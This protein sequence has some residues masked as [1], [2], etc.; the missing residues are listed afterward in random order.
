VIYKKYVGLNLTSGTKLNKKYFK[1][2]TQVNCISKKLIK[3][4]RQNVSQKYSGSWLNWWRKRNL[5]YYGLCSAINAKSITYKA[6]KS[7]V[8]VVD[9]DT[10]QSSVQ[11]RLRTGLP[12]RQTLQLHI[13]AY[14]RQ[15]M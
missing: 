6:T 12:R 11:V 9:V 1:K 13:C 8:V 14:K 5:N 7:V 2:L 15:H 10:S 3:K 4:T